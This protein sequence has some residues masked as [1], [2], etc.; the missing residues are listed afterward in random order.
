MVANVERAQILANQEFRVNSTFR[1]IVSRIPDTLY[2]AKKEAA[3]SGMAK[4]PEGIFA[5]TY[6]L[7]SQKLLRP[8]LSDLSHVSQD[9]LNTIGGFEYNPERSIDLVGS[10]IAI[11]LARET[12]NIP[13]FWMRTEESAN[14]QNISRDD[15]S[16]TEGMR[17]AVVDP[18]DMT[19]SIPRHDPVQ[20]T[21]IAIYNKDGSVRTIGIMSLVNDG[22]IFIDQNENGTHRIH[23]NDDLYI[24]EDRPAD[25]PLRIA[26]KTRRMY[27]LNNLPLMNQG[28]I[29]A[30]DCDSGFATLGLAQGNIDTIVDAFK[31]NP[32]YEV[33]IWVHA[34]QLMGFPVTDKDGNK[35]DIA[36]VMRHVIEHHEDDTYRIPFVVSRTPEI[37]KKVLE[38]LKST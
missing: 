32:W 13:H 37:H 38:L 20:T 35:V 17:F 31:G 29:W 27:A 21:G 22:F 25:A 28:Y 12:N 3:E 6:I 5:L 24:K 30:M 34:A 1:D 19:S 26:A 9:L 23:T 15:A 7:A 36:E 33:A 11:T 4:T 18:M 10:D 14:W 2:F 16:P 8:A